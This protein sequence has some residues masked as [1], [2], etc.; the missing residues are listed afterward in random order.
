MNF[1]DG[2]M[3]DTGTEDFYRIFHEEYFKGTCDIDPSPFLGP[4]ASLL[5]KGTTVLDVGCGSGRDMKWL[6]ERGFEVF[7]FERSPELAELACRHRGCE[8]IVGDYETFDFGVLNFGAILLVGALV[9]LPHE[10]APIVFRRIAKAI[11]RNPG[12]I[13]LSLKKGT[14]SF[15]DARKR[16]FYLWDEALLRETLEDGS[17]RI[18]DCRVDR[19]AFNLEDRWISMIIER[20]GLYERKSIGE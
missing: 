17:T 14:G 10:K 15:V 6:K 5:P 19:S 9:H 7:G 4:F 2:K 3:D 20:N 16:T 8:V 11:K 13:F 1:A 12:H 18:L